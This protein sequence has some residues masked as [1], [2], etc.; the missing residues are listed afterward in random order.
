MTLEEALER[1][2]ELEDAI[3][4][5]TDDLTEAQDALELQEIENERLLSALES[6]EVI[7]GG[8]L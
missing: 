3:T 1:N 8:A 6:V 7:V 5:L 2:T 4:D